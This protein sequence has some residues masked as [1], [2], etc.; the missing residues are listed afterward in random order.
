MNRHLKKIK[1]IYFYDKKNTKFVLD[2]IDKISNGIIVFYNPECIG[3]MNSTLE[4]F[5]E[6]STV[7]LYEL[8][9]K[10]QINE[11]SGKIA[12]KKIK[13]VIF[14]TMAFGYKELAENIYQKNSKIKIKFLWHGSHSLFV[15]PN[16]QRFLENILELSKRKIV[17]SIGFLKESMANCYKEKGY[18]S[19]FV[20]NDVS[21]VNKENYVFTNN[22]EKD[23]RIGIYSSGDRW[24]KNTYNQL[25]ACAMVKDAKI[26]MIPKTNL[27]ISFCKLMGIK[28]QDD[29]QNIAVKREQLLERMAKNTVNLYVT[30][31]ECAPMIPL[32]SLEVGVPCIIGNN[33]HYFRGT[34]LQEY[35]VVK[36]EDSIDEIFEK[37]NLCVGKKDE[38]IKSYKEWKKVYSKQAKESVINFLNS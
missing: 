32:E 7:A 21:V 4:M 11:I 18:N 3:I 14:S 12:S 20:M 35:L 29:S 1:S 19:Y 28:F 6:E 8:F 9:N 10:K 15:N 26:D 36:E 30:F 31:T 23:I 25:S 17:S 33:T 5:D 24:E 34:N 27:A 22:D 37:I 13:Q 2:K 38:I 16:E